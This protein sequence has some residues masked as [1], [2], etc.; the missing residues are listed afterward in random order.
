MNRQDWEILVC[1]IALLSCV[2][3][4]AFLVTLFFIR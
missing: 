1:K 2:A 4:I 3:I